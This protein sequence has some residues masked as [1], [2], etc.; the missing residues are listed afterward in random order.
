M[1]VFGLTGGIASGK[2]T[3]SNLLR[4]H[5][6]SVIDA[7]VLAREV[8]A[9]GTDGLREVAAR[10]PGVVAADGTLDRKAL[11][12][13]VF[14][15]D[16]ERAALNAIL[17]PKIRALAKERTDALAARG[18]AIAIY[19]APLLVENKLYQGMDG[20]I[21][22]WVD[23]ATQLERL[24]ARDGLTPDAAR[25]RVAAQLPLSEKK[26]VATW[27]I[28][29]GGTLADTRRQVDALVHRLRAA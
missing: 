7:D 6:L 19:D 13:R 2:S 21:L 17:H 27:L 4:E 29:N 12:A 1:K 16:D 3:V 14:A 24:I 11:G 22:V 5:G 9:P 23:D 10:F 18:E 28:D 15:R 26:K 8:V 25:A 20:V